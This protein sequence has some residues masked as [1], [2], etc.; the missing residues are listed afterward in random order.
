LFVT[1]SEPLSNSFPTLLYAP[2]KVTTQ[3]LGRDALEAP[4]T[5][6]ARHIGARRLGVDFTIDQKGK[7]TIIEINGESS[8]AVGTCLAIQS[9]EFDNLCAAKGLISLL[10]D[11]LTENHGRRSEIDFSNLEAPRSFPSTLNSP[12]GLQTLIDSV[13]KFLKTNNPVSPGPFD[14]LPPEAM[15]LLAAFFSGRN[16]HSCLVDLAKIIKHTDVGY[17][18]HDRLGAYS[19]IINVYHHRGE[20]QLLL[21]TIS[22]FPDAFETT[23]HVCYY[24]LLSFMNLSMFREANTQW[25]IMDQAEGEI[26]SEDTCVSLLAK[27]K[28]SKFSRYGS[29]FARTMSR[30]YPD[31]KKVSDAIADWEWDRDLRTSGLAAPH[32]GTLKSNEELPRIPDLN[33]LDTGP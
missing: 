3:Q 20:N 26:L 28:E 10:S 18:E 12:K 7:L 29:Q 2:S 5:A 13:C 22:E 16:W 33:F 24:K 25:R 14:A 23:T 30:W 32:P 21:D 15:G 27:C 19:Q 8:G 1:A 9:P 31:S 17:A 6:L 11:V 4:L